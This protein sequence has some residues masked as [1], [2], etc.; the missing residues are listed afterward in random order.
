MKTNIIKSIILGAAAIMVAGCTEG[1][2]FDYNQNVAKC[3]W[4]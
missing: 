2:K 4:L 1:D 3:V